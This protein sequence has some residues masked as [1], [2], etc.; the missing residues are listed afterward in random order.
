MVLKFLLTICIFAVIVDL[1]METAEYFELQGNF[2][3]D[4][5]PINLTEI[6]PNYS[7][8]PSCHNGVVKLNGV[9]KYEGTNYGIATNRG[10][11]KYR[12]L[13]KITLNKIDYQCLRL[14]GTILV[15]IIN[16]I[17]L[18]KLFLVPRF[19][20]PF[21]LNTHDINI[22]NFICIMFCL[23]CIMLLLTYSILH[24]RRVFSAVSH[25]WRIVYD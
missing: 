13:K 24:I 20:F 18:K 2:A 8:S 22:S 17:V 11:V 4:Y 19:F 9:T 6:Y 16:N 23:I 14:E 25:T 10:G 15:I 12:V 7:A 5:Q 3:E 1:S 21:R